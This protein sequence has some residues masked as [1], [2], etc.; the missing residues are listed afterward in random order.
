MS[1]ILNQQFSATQSQTGV[2]PTTVVAQDPTSV[3][4]VFADFA[5]RLQNV[6]QNIK[7]NSV[8]ADN[9]LSQIELSPEAILISSSKIGVVGQVTFADWHRDV[10]GV[11]T[12]IIDPSITQI[13]GGVI[14]TGTIENLSATSYID[15]DATGTTPF[16]VSS[17]GVSI[18]ANGD[19]TLG[20]G[21]SALT[22]NGTNLTIGSATINSGTG[23]TINTIDSNATTAIA[24]AN[25]ALSQVSAKLNKSASDI[26]TGAVTVSNAGGFSAG[27]ITWNSSGVLTGGSGV[28]M[29]SNGI[30]AAQAGVVTMTLPISGSPTFSGNVTGASITSSTY[31]DVSGYV[32]ASGTITAA[33]YTGS[34]VG[35]CSVGYGV[36]GVSHSTVY[37][38]VVGYNSVGGPGVQAVSSGIALEVDGQMS[39]SSNALVSNLNAQYVNG[40]EFGTQTTGSAT[41]TFVSTNKPGSSSS[42][43]WIPMYNTSGTILGYIPFWN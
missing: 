2:V 10:T 4:A 26:L 32:Y 1:L 30:V 6:E 17:S 25:S 36:V 38:G 7:A 31:I 9:V 13:R 23:N 5:K 11:A 35:E 27:T 22:W 19:F 20:S 18:Q 29:T 28:A 34:V 3:Q 43:G 42:N 39:I 12:G 37:G 40:F 41:A 14:K 8:G 24:N 33:S 21:T 15:L 16:I